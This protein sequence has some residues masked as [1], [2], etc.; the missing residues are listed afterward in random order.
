MHFYTSINNNYMPKARILAKSVKRHHPYS[1]FSLILSDA[2][3]ESVN[4]DEEPFDEI[5]C[6]DELNLPVENL[7]NWIFFIQ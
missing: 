6:I 2:L 3:P 7:T 1:K 5:L 4:P